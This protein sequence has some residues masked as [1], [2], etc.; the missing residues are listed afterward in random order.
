MDVHVIHETW[1]GTAITLQIAV[2]FVY[3]SALAVARRV[4]TP[5]AR[6]GRGH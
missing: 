6:G 1:L 3:L 5:D 4:L 2:G